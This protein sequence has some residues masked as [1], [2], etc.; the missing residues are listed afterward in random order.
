MDAEH[1][2]GNDKLRHLMQTS[3]AFIE[4]HLHQAVD[5]NT[6]RERTLAACK[7]IIGANV[8][9]L[10]DMRDNPSKFLAWFETVSLCDMSVALKFAVQYNLWGGTILFLGTKKHHD[11]YLQDISDGKL[12]GVFGL[13]E[14]GHG[15]NVQGLETTSTYDE[16][17]REFIINSPTWNSQKYWPGNIAT[18]GQMATVFARLILKGKD[19]GVHAFVVPIR[20]PPSPGKPYGD[21]LPGV[22]IRDIGYKSSFNGIDN[23]GLSFKSVRIPRDNM[24]NRFSEV[25]DS[26]EYQSPIPANRHFAATMFGPPK[27]KEQPII[28][29][30]THQRRL[31]PSIARCFALDFMHKYI[32]TSNKSADVLHSYSSGIKA[33][34]TWESFYMLQEARECMG[35]QGM[36][37]PAR[38]TTI[39]DH[40]D[41][42]LTGEG[43]NIVMCQQVAK[44]LL[45][46]YHAAMKRGGIFE[47]ELDYVNNINSRPTTENW[48]SMSYQQWL[49]EMREYTMIKELHKNMFGSDSNIKTSSVEWYHLWNKCL[50]LCVKLARANVDR[51]IHSVFLKKI[52]DLTKEAD[53]NTLQMLKKLC[54]L[55]G[56]VH[57]QRDL[58]LYCSTGIVVGDNK[59]TTLDDEI[60]MLCKEITPFSRDL[61]ASFKIP[62]R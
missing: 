7:E 62:T 40:V 60:T 57:I 32:I 58:G 11:K 18:H 13:T 15:S 61:V 12:L 10:L 34:T 25:T 44:F 46:N 31:I 24:L 27:S 8:V 35:G 49:L 5:G 20:T 54:C 1:V 17:T 6:H 50:P 2:Q 28:S 55:D 22:E 52:I 23:G 3:D 51:L 56:L 29:Y 30:S 9:N 37:L 59:W 33:C 39:R 16:K 53:L 14:L 36:R 41:L 45:L 26:G 48:R 43:D 38:L 19:H 42:G 4:T 47:G 21:V